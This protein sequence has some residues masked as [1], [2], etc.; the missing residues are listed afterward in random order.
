KEFSA[1]VPDDPQA[2]L[3]RSALTTRLHHSF[4]QLSKP[5]V[6][7]V[8]GNALGGGAGLA[9]AADLMV[10]ANDARLGYPELK[11]GIVAAVVIA[12]LVRQLG[13]KQAFELVALAEPISGE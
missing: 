13:R 8:H 12:N 2:V 10:I 11:H 7:A 5:V 4:S 6:S 3:A 9:L 1:L